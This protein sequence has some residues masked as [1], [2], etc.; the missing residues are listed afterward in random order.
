MRA[1]SSS[2]VP[3]MPAATRRWVEAALAR[4]PRGLLS[5]IDG[6]LSA[7]ASSPEEARLIRGVRPLLR[8]LSAT[9]DVVAAISGRH[10]LDARRMVGL[11]QLTYIGNHGL[12]SLAPGARAPVVAP[13]ALAWQSAIA[14][15]LHEARE[16]LGAAFPLLR[17][18]NKGVTASIHYRQAPNPT[19]AHAAIRRALD[20]LARQRELRVTEGRL[21]VELR[22]PLDY[23][24][25]SSTRA[26]V[27][28]HRLA[29]ALYLGD[30][31]TDI[32]AFTALRDL[33][34]SGERAGIAVA[35]GSAEAPA[36]L[37]AAADITLA[38]ITE[39]PPFLRWVLRVT[40]G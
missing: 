40:G 3:A 2:Y 8:R 24:K 12:E 32:D 13:A 28:E 4:R 16:Q 17:F 29:C 15:T 30:D 22:P 38:S 11:P 14:D 21:V 37:S 31:R 20:P 19:A 6:T 1:T 36:T 33:R 35:V 34:A 5:D 18:E 23:D 7:I 10:A 27:R 39:V 26:L 9:F 25:G